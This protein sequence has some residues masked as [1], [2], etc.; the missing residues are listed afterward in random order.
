MPS[1]Q[2]S[3]PAPTYRTRPDALG[4][5]LFWRGVACSA[6][7]FAGYLPVGMVFGAVAV[8]T[9]ISS[10]LPVLMSICMYSGAGQMAGVQALAAGQNPMAAAAGILVIN[11]RLVPMS[12]F[13]A[14]LLRRAS[15][16]DRLLLAH[17][18]T[19]EVFALDLRQDRRPIGFHRGIHTA[20]WTAWV[21]GTA[22][23]VT[24]G[25][26]LPST[27]TAFALPSLFIT[28]AVNELRP[29]KSGRRTWVTA[30]TV[31]LVTVCRA[32]GP[33]G[34]LVATSAVTTL[35]TM[36]DRLRRRTPSGRH[37]KS[38]RR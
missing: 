7:V 29:I 12:L 36:A 9:G 5:E 16:T 24:L 14:P 38:R 1:A 37:R 21:G 8:Q 2:E 32:M 11:I 19:D 31:V 25:P 15:R 26:I 6:G 22:A 27:W 3:S 30:A 20:C 10:W 18:L 33:C 23:G 28:L 34:S 17:T 4:G 13:V 35:L